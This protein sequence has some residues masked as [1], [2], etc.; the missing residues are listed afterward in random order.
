MSRATNARRKWC[1][2]R[3]LPREGKFRHGLNPLADGVVSGPFESEGGRQGSVYAQRLRKV[4]HGAIHQPR[5]V[6]ARAVSPRQQR[7][8]DV[9]EARRASSCIR[10]SVLAQLYGLAVRAQTPSLKRDLDR[11]T[12][13]CTAGSAESAFSTR[14][15]Q[16]G[17]LVGAPRSSPSRFSPFRRPTS[18]DGSIG[19]AFRPR[20]DLLKTIV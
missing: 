11:L 19:R 10:G 12:L 16:V 20:A 17:I 6:N 2:P 7:K 13:T 5:S 8:L 14:P 3:S 15:A 18:S 4:L 9:D 1:T